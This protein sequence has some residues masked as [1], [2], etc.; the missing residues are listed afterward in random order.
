MGRVGLHLAPVRLTRHPM[1]LDGLVVGQAPTAGERVHRNSTLTV[2][3]WHPAEP[4][5]R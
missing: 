3:L 1:P 4:S 2:R 5:A